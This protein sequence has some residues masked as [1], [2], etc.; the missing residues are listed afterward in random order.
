[1]HYQLGASAALLDDIWIGYVTADEVR[2]LIDVFGIAG[3][4]IVEDCDLVAIGDECVDE[5][6][7]DEAGTAGDEN[8]HA[9]SLSP[10]KPRSRTLPS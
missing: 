9:N 5:V 2:L 8:S 4:Q 10:R 7:T 1:V 6:G 3:A